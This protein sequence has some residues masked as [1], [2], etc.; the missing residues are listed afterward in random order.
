MTDSR[1]EPRKPLCKLT[2]VFTIEGLGALPATLVSVVL[3]QS[4]L[5]SAGFHEVVW[6]IGFRMGTHVLAHSIF[7]VGILVTVALNEALGLARSTI[8]IFY[9]VSTPTV[10][11]AARISCHSATRQA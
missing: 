5:S 9:N 3:L 6:V 11:I 7:A 1:I 4:S 8:R 10:S 2:E